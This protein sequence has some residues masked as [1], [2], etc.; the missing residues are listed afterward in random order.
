MKYRRLSV[1]LTLACSLAV[2][3]PGGPSRPTAREY[4]NPKDKSVLIWTPGGTFTMGSD[5]GDP[6]EKPPHRITIAGFWLGA[7]EVTNAQ[8]ARFLNATG[9]EEP[10]FWKSPGY[11]DPR[12]PVVGLTWAE[13]KQ[14]AAW[15]GLRLPTEAEWEYA[16]AAGRQLRYPTATGTISHDLANYRGTAGK[17]RWKGPAPVGSFPPTP[18][19]LFDMA[20]NAWEWTSSYYLPY[21]FSPKNERGSMSVMRGG[22]WF[23]GER[24]QTTTYRRRF[25]K[26]LEYDYAGLRLALSTKPPEKTKK[27]T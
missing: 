9:G 20:G 18:L 12:Q 27:K 4:T 2:T 22:A 21:P 10:M 1:A 7:F 8:Y 11:S 14:Y 26:H 3:A 16:A 15:A 24:Y 5:K 19:G 13:A 23:F 25:A 17:D 6:D